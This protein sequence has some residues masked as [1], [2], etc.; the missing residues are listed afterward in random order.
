[1]PALVIAERFC[2]PPTSANGGYACGLVARFLDGPAQVTLRSP[3]PLGRPLDLRRGG[4]G[5]SLWDDEVLVAEAQAG[6]ATFDVPPRVALD[7]ARRAAERYEWLHDHPYPTCF[8]CGPRRAERDGLRIFAGPVAGRGVYAAPWTPDPDLAGEDGLVR[9][10]FAWSALDCPSG[11]VTN[12][13]GDV[14]RVLLGRLAA[15]LRRPV[16]PGEDHVVTAWPIGRDGR[17]LHTGSALF[18]ASG[19][20]L[21]AARAVWIDVDPSQTPRARAR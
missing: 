14:G 9:P 1:M 6:P 12:T 3:P 4:Q 19:E 17:K 16:R 11:L 8:V 5:V 20:L 13:F 7:D 15:D 2:G 21:A 18:T 10:E